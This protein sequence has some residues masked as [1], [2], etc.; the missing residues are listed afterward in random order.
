[1]EVCKYHKPRLDTLLEYC[2]CLYKLEGCSC[3]GKLHIFLDDNNYS[4]DDVLF[5]LNECVTHPEEEESELGILICKEFLKLNE[6]ERKLFMKMWNGWEVPDC[7]TYNFCEYCPY[8]TEEP[9][10]ILKKG[11]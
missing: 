11:E 7:I 10:L 2:K 9:Y 3:G 5:C 4:T 6:C 8:M 1:M